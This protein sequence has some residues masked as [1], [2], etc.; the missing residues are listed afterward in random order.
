MEFIPTRRSTSSSV[1][2]CCWSWRRQLELSCVH[3]WQS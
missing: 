1:F 3:S 2:H